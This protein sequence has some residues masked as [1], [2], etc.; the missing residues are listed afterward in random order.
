L[1]EQGRVAEALP[2]VEAAVGH[3]RRLVQADPETHLS[4][5]ARAQTSD[6]TLWSYVNWERAVS[7]AQEA[8]RIY[9]HLTRADVNAL[10]DVARSLSDLLT[11]LWEMAAIRSCQTLNPTL[12]AAVTRCVTT[13]ENSCAG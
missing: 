5:L 6:A 12:P 9:R 10:P 3:Y 1:A 7:P 8:T 2:L 13:L 11:F 4:D